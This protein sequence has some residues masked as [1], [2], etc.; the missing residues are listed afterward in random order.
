MLHS[1]NIN[2]EIRN[3]ILKMKFKRGIMLPFLSL[4]KQTKE[5]HPQDFSGE[6]YAITGTGAS[7]LLESCV[8]GLTQRQYLP[9]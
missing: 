9:C 3:V 6:H 2:Y 1:N 5:T 8:A 7:C 4:Q